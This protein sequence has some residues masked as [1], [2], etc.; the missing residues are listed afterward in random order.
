MEIKVTG[1]FHVDLI[2]E[3]ITIDHTT[4]LEAGRMI[5]D[6][7][8]DGALEGQ[9][10][11]EMISILNASKSAGGYVAAE[12]FEGTLEGIP[13]SFAMQHYGKFDISGQ[14]LTLEIIPGSGEGELSNIRGYMDIR[15]EDGVHYYDLTAEV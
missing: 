9:S 8:F 1:T 7:T 4:S 14:S 15:V 6:K 13:G 3:T 5:I 12:I 2:P 11:G 10:N